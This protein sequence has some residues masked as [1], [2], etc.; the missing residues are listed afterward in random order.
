M[1][2]EG[3]GKPLVGG[4]R[5]T[6]EDILDHDHRGIDDQAKIDRAD[7]QQVGRL[8]G[9]DQQNDREEQGKRN[10]RRDN[11]GTAQIAEK[12]PLHQ[13]DQHNPEHH[14]VQYGVGGDVDQVAAVVNALDTDT[15]RQYVGAVDLLDFGL[16]A[17]DRRHALLAAAHQHDA[18]YDVV[19][20]VLPGDA[21][22]RQVSDRHGRDVADPYRHAVRGRDHGVADLVHRMDQRDAAHDRRLWPEIDGL[23][24]DVDVAVVEDLQH[25]RQGQAVGY[26]PVEIDR[27]LIRLCLSAPAI[28]VDDPRHRLEAA[29]ED[30]ILNRLQIRRR[31]AGWAQHPISVDFA[32]RTP[33]RDLRQ[34]TIRQRSQLRQPVDHPL[35]RFVIGEVV[36]ELQFDVGKAEQR[37][38]SDRGE[39]RDARHLD[40]DRDRDVALD[41]VGGLSGI[42]RDN[43]DQ[44]RHRVGIGLDVEPEETGDADPEQKQ[45]QQDYQHTPTQRKGN[46]RVHTLEYVLALSAPRRLNWRRRLG[47]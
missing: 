7:R 2:D 16:D 43:V 36:S 41:L 1:Q 24:A 38:R 14:V 8:A 9:N 13:K 3:T 37:D 47:R 42:L 12:Q 21:E 46:D 40:L 25:L 10:C 4:L 28:D 18:L 44:R 17:L 30:P 20:I 45:Q 32:N 26:Q 31:I 33:R 5:Q 15:R 19:V 22:A 6:P 27:D 39:M 23:S 34:G 29:F 35:L 11:Q